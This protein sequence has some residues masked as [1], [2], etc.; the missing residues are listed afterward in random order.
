MHR[1]CLLLPALVVYLCLLFE[2]V[3]I[4]TSNFCPATLDCTHG[5]IQNI[6]LLLG[7]CSCSPSAPGSRS[8]PGAKIF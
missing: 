3:M 5:P 2:V 7:S 6:Q 4:R 8:M 1:G